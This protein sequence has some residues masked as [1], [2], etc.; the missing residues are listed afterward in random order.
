MAKSG[1]ESDHPMTEQSQRV[2]YFECQ[3]PLNINPGILKHPLKRSEGGF[4]HKITKKFLI[5][6]NVLTNS[7][8]VINFV[9]II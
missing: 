6:T 9:V 1:N 4:F 5:D 2:S 7:N 3:I 8:I